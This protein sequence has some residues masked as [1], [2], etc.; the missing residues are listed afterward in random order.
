MNDEEL[1]KIESLVVDLNTNL[2]ILNSAV[3]SFNEDLQISDLVNFVGETYKISDEIRNIFY[4]S[5]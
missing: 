3:M 2:N 5:L 4:N 1:N